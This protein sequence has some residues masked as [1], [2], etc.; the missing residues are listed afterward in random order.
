MKNDKIE[1]WAKAYKK[2][3]FAFFSPYCIMKEENERR[4]RSNEKV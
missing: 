1:I 4:E 2:R 3:V